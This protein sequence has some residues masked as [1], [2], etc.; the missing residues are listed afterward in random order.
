MTVRARGDRARRR[1]G[2]L[3]QARRKEPAR[4]LARTKSNCTH[5]PS[6][7]HTLDSSLP[8]GA[9]FVGRWLAAAVLLHPSI[10]DDSLFSC[11]NE[12]REK[13]PSPLPCPKALY[14]QA[15]RFCPFY[16]WLF[17]GAEGIVYIGILVREIFKDLILHPQRHAVVCLRHRACHC[18]NRIGISAN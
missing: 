6:V 15:I 3:P 11:R 1:D 4:A 14:L 2:G 17:D 12:K 13:F 18:G 9:F 16:P 5:S 7:S 10:Q 8:E